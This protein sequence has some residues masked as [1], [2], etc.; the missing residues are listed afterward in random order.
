MYTRANR[1]CRGP[2]RTIAIL[3]IVADRPHPALAQRGC[4]TTDSRAED[5]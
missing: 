2:R 4:P 5:E 1:L 3:V